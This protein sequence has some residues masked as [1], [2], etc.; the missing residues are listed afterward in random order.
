MQAI[1]I[2]LLISLASL[3]IGTPSTETRLIG[4]RDGSKPTEANQT[5]DTTNQPLDGAAEES[6]A[7]EEDK[8]VVPV[9]GLPLYRL[10]QRIEPTNYDLVV[11]PDLEAL[12]FEGSVQV[13]LRVLARRDGGPQHV[14]M[15]ANKIVLHAHGDLAV[16][17]VSYRDL[18]SSARRARSNRDRDSNNNTST[19]IQILNVCRDEHYQLLVI[20][21]ER[22]L[23][24][25]SRGLLKLTFSGL[26][27][28]NLYGFY[29]SGYT[30]TSQVDGKP[31][32]RQRYHAVTQ[33][34]AADA[35][36]LFPCFDEPAFKA[37][38][39]VT[40]V[41]PSD[42]LALSNMEPVEWGLPEAASKR[43]LGAANETAQV[44]FA[45]TPPMSSYLL[46][47]FVGELDYVERSLELPQKLQ[48]RVFT[49]LGARELGHF[50]LDVVARALPLL[51]AHFDGA[52]C[53]AGKIDLLPL[54]D[55]SSGAMENWGL[56]TFKE[57]SL[58]ADRKEESIGQKVYVAQTIV[59]ELAHHWFGNLVTM[60]WWNEIW[61]NEGMASWLEAKLVEEM[62][63]EQ[64]L[65][66]YLTLK[67][68]LRALQA[69]SSRFVHPIELEEEQV[70]GVEDIDVLFDTI[71]YNK[72]SAIVRQMGSPE[73]LGAEVF[74]TALKY[75][76]NKHKYANT[77]LEDLLEA[78][79]KSG[80]NNT[81]T[82]ASGSLEATSAFLRNWIGQ[83][84][85]P[86]I[87]ATLIERNA[88]EGEL[89]LLEQSRFVFENSSALDE[90]Q[91]AQRWIVPISV[92]VRGFDENDNE[93]HALI[94]QTMN[95]TTQLTV[96]LPGWFKRGAEGAW[97]K[98]NVNFTGFYR[99]AYSEALGEALSR[100]VLLGE[101]VWPADR[102]NL[103]D[104]ARALVEAKRMPSY[105]LVALMKSFANES[106]GAVLDKLARTFRELLVLYRWSTQA[107]IRASLVKFGERLFGH[108]IY[109]RARLFEPFRARKLVAPADE[110]YYEQAARE[111]VLELLA[112]E[113]DFEPATKLLLE[114]FDNC[115]LRSEPKRPPANL[116][117]P[118]YR[119]VAARGSDEQW[120]R[121]LALDE[122][123][124]D[125]I[126]LL[127]EERR[128]IGD[129]LTRA[130]KPERLEFAWSWLKA[131]PEVEDRLECLA[132]LFES[133]QGRRLIKRLVAGERRQLIAMGEQA[134]VASF[135][136]ELRAP[137][138]DMSHSGE[139]LAELR[140]PF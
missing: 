98:V 76:I 35:R 94:R 119:C 61:L 54:A 125:E 53:P 32:K 41:Y 48:V 64:D 87:S 122:R 78:L 33:L 75:Y 89:L 107:A 134:Q 131:H 84:G 23:K 111:N 58:L 132:A 57:S 133:E 11:K 90:Q 127:K 63:P 117:A 37:T 126:A 99:V 81:T 105:K 28:N 38:F 79:A 80:R 49:P 24:D 129:A 8:Q 139:L 5:G 102:V 31:V 15:D 112:V 59:H 34:Q 50:A 106:S 108:W 114:L 42:R 138:D 67:S 123:Q 86:L 27:S 14:E 25:R 137:A 10:P 16:D 3:L 18:G 19:Y 104:D 12:R 40:L 17:V 120:E 29:K 72:A 47:L 97:L 20:T 6:G 60:D 7:E 124:G 43:E 1:R 95:A 113:L 115:T 51:C 30:K 9:C 130:T 46:A 73:L 121:L 52:E 92:L 93:Q 100:A 85:H 39:D 96:E 13:S 136:E 110:T 70:E 65:A 4:K 82:L 116:R 128:L 26:L 77:N 2:V 83:A 118:V 21:L 109:L 55:F 101:L 62:F 56:I 22:D 103:L 135:V 69:D 66:F 71:S 44:R 45:R 74:R 68:H 88:D 36:R 140:K 91:A